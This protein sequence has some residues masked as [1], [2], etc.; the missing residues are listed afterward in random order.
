MPA[1]TVI[2]AGSST[3]THTE[4]FLLERSRELYEKTSFKK[5]QHFDQLCKIRVR[6]QI[7]DAK[8]VKDTV[9]T[10]KTGE[11]GSFHLRHTHILCQNRMILSAE[12]CEPRSA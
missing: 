9:P 1:G 5:S 4:S 10:N 7:T 2:S 6:L 12:L 11:G 3:S 8:A